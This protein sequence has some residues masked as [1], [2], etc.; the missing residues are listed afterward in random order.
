MQRY[1]NIEAY[2]EYVGQQRNS[3]FGERFRSQFRDRRGT[4]ELAM[5]AAPSET[6]YE[7]FCR[8][9]AVMTATEKDDVAGLNDEEIRAI[10]QRGQADVGNVSIFVNGYVLAQKKADAEAG[11]GQ[12]D[13]CE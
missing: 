9:V 12:P 8:A 4:A 3:K 11:P 7:D 2:L 6:E 1:A 13:L 5:L 10:A